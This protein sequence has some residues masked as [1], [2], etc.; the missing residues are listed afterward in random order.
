[1]PSR[2]PLPFTAELVSPAQAIAFVRARKTTAIPKFFTI[3][4]VAELLEVSTRTVRRLDRH[5]GPGDASVWGC[6]SRRRA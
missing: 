6:G 3:A 2:R 4:Q 5:R 1:M